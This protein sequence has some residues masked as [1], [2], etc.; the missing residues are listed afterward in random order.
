MTNHSIAGNKGVCNTLDSKVCTTS[1]AGFEASQ[2]EL[3]PLTHWK[4]P[5]I[6]KTMIDVLSQS[7]LL[8]H[9][10]ACSQDQQ[11]KVSTFASP[12][13]AVATGTFWDLLEST[14]KYTKSVASC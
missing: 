5:P 11:Y 13:L 7:N 3:Y 8:D 1:V 14:N 12:N 9:C 6:Q 10:Y 2:L 4:H